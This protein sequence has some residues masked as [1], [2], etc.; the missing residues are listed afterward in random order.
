MRNRSLVAETRATHEELSTLIAQGRDRLLELA[1]RRNEQADTLRAAL[2]AAD[3]ET[4]TDDFTL[5]LFEQFGVHSEE[6]AARTYIL[7]PEY[8]STEGFP[9]LKDGPQQITFD[10]L[11]RT[12]ARGISAAASRS[13]DGR[14]RD[15]LAA[16]VPNTAT[17]RSSSTIR[18]R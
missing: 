11:D 15:G 3:N 16:R 14:R 12:R 9:G 8:L 2:I 10:A 5:K 18:C 6:S 7:D 17:P 1:N 13:S 4:A